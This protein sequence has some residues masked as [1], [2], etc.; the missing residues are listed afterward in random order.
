MIQ[1]ETHIRVRYAETDQMG[2]VYYGV[3]PQYFEVGRAELIRD[4]GM[5]YREMEEMGVLMPVVDLHV[6]YLRPAQYDD[7]LRIRTQIRALP[8]RHIVMDSEVF[9]EKGKLCVAGRV[10]LAFMDAKTR[11]A[12]SPPAPFVDL[13]Q[14]HWA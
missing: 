1:H 8:E 5:T 6:R 12:V 7:L 2:I 11:K 14:E 4:L 13:L 10:K 9:N 3:Y